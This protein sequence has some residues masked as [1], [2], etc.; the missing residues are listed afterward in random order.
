MMV[1]E[2]M[3]M[4]SASRVTW[5]KVPEPMVEMPSVSSARCDCGTITRYHARETGMSTK[6]GT[7]H[8]VVQRR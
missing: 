8:L 7:S 4:T 3:I 5:E 2:V 6:D 1:A